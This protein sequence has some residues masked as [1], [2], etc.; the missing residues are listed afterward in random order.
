ML[1]VDRDRAARVFGPGV[2]EQLARLGSELQKGPSPPKL[3]EQCTDM[4]KWSATEGGDPF[5]RLG[6]AVRAEL[7]LPA[8]PSQGSASARDEPMSARAI[9]G[10]DAVE[11]DGI[12]WSSVPPAVP[13]RELDPTATFEVVGPQ[14]GL[15]GLDAVVDQ[16]LEQ[17]AR[18]T[19]S[20][21][22]IIGPPGAGR[23]SAIRAL[24]TRLA[25]EG[26]RIGLA[27]RQVVRVR[28]EAVLGAHRADE[29][30][31]IRGGAPNTAI[32]VLDDLEVL[33]LLSSPAVDL[34]LRGVVRSILG[35]PDILSVATLDENFRNRL[36]AEEPELYAELEMV[37]LPALDD[38]QLR[39]IARSRAP[40]LARHHRV[41]IPS[42]MREIAMQPRR[43][44]ETRAHPGLLLDRLDRAALRARLRRHRE[45]VPDDFELGDAVSTWKAVEPDDL[46]ARLRERVKGQ[47]RAIDVLTARLALTSA[48]LDLRPY[49][50]NGVFLFA[51][52]T[53]VGKTAL[54]KALAAELFGA[55]DRMI[56][57]DMSEY[58]EEWSVNRL[59]GPHPGYVG[60]NEPQG[61]FTTKVIDAPVSIVLLD[62]IEKAHPLVWNAFLQVF[63]DG[64]MTDSR[65]RVARFGDTVII[66]TSNLGARAFSANPVGF[67]GAEP[68]TAATTA[69]V[70]ASIERAMPPEFVNRLDGIVV[71]EPLG[72][73]VIADIAKSEIARSFA[74]LSELGWHLELSEAAVE[75]IARDGYSPTYGARHIE[76]NIE[77]HVLGRLV[78]LQPGK[79]RGDVHEGAF[80]WTAA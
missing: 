13:E 33:L 63:D 15:V 21:P 34:D 35:R 1:I 36:E 44:G 72:P 59:Y 58:A 64:R 29:L 30:R 76:R 2:H 22:C 42:A 17:L 51:G 70:R 74:A 66:M 67:L 14:A 20:S 32:L 18:F 50:P 11:G 38:A 62:E 71:F 61:W 78:G 37:R 47:E 48:R 75:W 3:S 6:D 54:A 25:T 65:G 28:A 52:P 16:L 56:R 10:E 39:E 12:D 79:Y 41:D 77:S 4:L 27:D 45:V 57:L 53:G 26:A 46:G 9:F 24:A 40:A 69:A 73:D 68:E 49:R 19:P 60:S 7:D 43:P 80:R 31:A 23:T 5:E 8:P 55:E